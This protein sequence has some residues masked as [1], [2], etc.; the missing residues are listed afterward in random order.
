MFVLD[1]DNYRV[2][3][4]QVGDTLGYVVVAGRGNGAAFNQIGTSYGMF[5]DSNWNIYISEQSNHRV[6]LWSQ[7]NL[8]AGVLV[9]VHCLFFFSFSFLWKQKKVAGGNG[10]GN[11]AEKLNSPWGVIVDINGS[12][13]V[14]DRGNHRIQ[15]WDTGSFLSLKQFK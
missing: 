8:T 5:V 6:T 1:R 15:K 3:K 12:I 2:L 4:W 13:Y 9:S 10:N 11:T 14:S 7:A